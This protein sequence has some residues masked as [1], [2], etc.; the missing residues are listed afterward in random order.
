MTQCF[1]AANQLLS[2]F[3][4]FWETKFWRCMV[5]FSENVEAL[6]AEC[7]ETVSVGW[8]KTTHWAHLINYLRT[9]GYQMRL[10]IKL[11]QLDRVHVWSRL[12]DNSQG[13]KG[14]CRSIQKP[15]NGTLNLLSVQDSLS[16]FN[17]EVEIPTVCVEKIW[18]IFCNYLSVSLHRG[19]VDLVH[20]S[21]WLS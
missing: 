14:E 20:L 11:F 19:F 21:R 5:F 2:F 9:D 18:N 13:I 16:N 12:G 6:T 1:A 7:S 15:E 3:L 17:S 4:S 10:S 8:L